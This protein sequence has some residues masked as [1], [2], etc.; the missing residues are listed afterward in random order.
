MEIDSIHEKGT[1]RMNEDALLLGSNFFGVFDGATSLNGF[2]T[3][4]GETGGYLASQTALEIF[5]KGGLSLKEKATVANQAIA[6]K[7]VSHQVDTDLKH[8]RWSTSVAAV[9]LHGDQLEWVQ[10]GDSDIILVYEDN[11]FQVMVESPNQDY[12]TLNSWRDICLHEKGTIYEVL[13]DQLKQV[14]NQM[15]I[16]YG[17]LN[18]EKEAVN[19]IQTGHHSIRGVKEVLLF[20]DGL[21]IPSRDV[22]YQ[23]NYSEWV[24]ILLS[25]GL[26]GLKNEIR[27]LEKTDPD[28][29]CFP[30]FKQHDDIAAISIR[31]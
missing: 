29:R 22:S 12:E 14:R 3:E 24:E 28:C 30:R 13:E 27:R 4:K 31:L 20:T 16:S 21:K 9:Q 5:Q 7:M 2:V 17:V 25:K 11:S 8:N 15:N 26:K 1:G 19:F 10:T 18:G 23:T 6:D